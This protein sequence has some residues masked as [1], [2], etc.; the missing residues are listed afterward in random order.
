VNASGSFTV[1]YTDNNGCAATS[2]A[3]L[4]DVSAAPVPT[5]NASATQACTGETVTLTSSTADTY[6][7]SNGETTQSISVTGTETVTVVTTNSNACSGVG[8]SAPVTVTFTQTPTAAGSFTTSGNIVT[9]ANASTNATDYSWDF[10]DFTNSSAAAPVHAY[11]ANGS[12]VVVL[13]ALN[14][15]C[16]DEFTLNV[17][18]S[19]SL[20]ELS[21]LSEVNL[22]PNP[23][24]AETT[25]SFN[26]QV[27]QD[28]NVKMINQLGQIVSSKLINTKEG[29]NKIELETARLNNGLYNILIET[30]N[31]LLIRKLIVQK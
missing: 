30:A 7:W 8:T 9:F 29:F 22:Y 12:Y 20:E 3:T 17:S 27:A 21:G 2:T 13:T 28:A 23:T 25:I 1:T 24:N 5:I 18:I 14:G 26:S 4:V 11:A 15:N 19:V 16:A 31:G 10:G 6:T